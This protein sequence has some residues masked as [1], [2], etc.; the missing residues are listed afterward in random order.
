[1]PIFIDVYEDKDGDTII[2]D[3]RDGIPLSYSAA[4]ELLHRLQAYLSL[5]EKMIDLLNQN[6]TY[7]AAVHTEQENNRAVERK[8][9][10]GHVYL[11]KSENGLCKIGCSGDYQNRMRSFLSLFPFK[12]E[13]LHVIATD[14]MYSLER[15]LHVLFEERRKQGEWFELD[16]ADIEYIKGLTS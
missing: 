7:K 1:M 11:V 14:D 13:L 6:A 4:L 2:S 9:K 12:V 10:A 3:L 15:R 16:S 8:T 5:G